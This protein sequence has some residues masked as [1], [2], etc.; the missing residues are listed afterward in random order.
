MAIAT[1]Y[2]TVIGLEV[3]SQLL[4]RTKMFCGCDAAYVGDAPNTHVCP[5]CLG[6]PGSLPVINRQ[7]VEFTVMTGLALHC[8]IN[9]HSKFDRKNY[10]YPDLMKGY[11]ISQYDAPFCTNGW[12]EIDLEGEVKRIGVNRVHLEEDTAKLFHR[13]SPWG[14]QYALVDVNRSGVPL[15]EIVS[16]PDLRSPAEARA[17]GLKLRQIL[18]Y[19]GVSE[20]DMEKGNMRFDTNVSIRPVGSSELGAKVEVKNINSFRSVIRALEYEVQRQGALLDEGGR[21]PQETR[22][23]VE[24]RGVTVSQ[25]SKES[26]HDY[27]YFPEPDLP[28]M[29][30]EPTWVSEVRARLPELPE[31]RR[32]RFAADYGLPP[33]DADLLTSTRA[34]ADFFEACLSTSAGG[35]LRDR[36]KAVANWL[37]GD[38]AHL[39]HEAGLDVEQSPVTPSQL[40]ALQDLVEAS[41]INLNTAREVFAQVFSTGQDPKRIVEERGLLQISDRDQLASTVARIIEGAP[42]A[43]TDYRAGKSQ[44]FTYLVGQVMKETRGRANPALVNALLKEQLHAS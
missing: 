16:E 26:A 41:T 22:G 19:L 15:M 4:T 21:I 5:V 8:S 40:N 23:W 25:R 43:V 31:A 20:A 32:R 30:L 6:L 17:Y 38:L 9:E 14:D 37:L 3:H 39:L 36:A 10:P 28:P 24:D 18:R 12:L 42:Q 1:R 11:Q 44:A 7:A 33:Y 29:H 27:R 2:E 13:V 35:D 34:Q